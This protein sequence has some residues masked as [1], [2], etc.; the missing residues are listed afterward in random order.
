M[1]LQATRALRDLTRCVGEFGNGC[2]QRKYDLLAT[3]EKRTLSQATEVLRLHESLCFLRAFP[4]DAQLLTQVEHMLSVFAE[5]V[6]V[7]RHRDQ[8]ANTGIAGTPIYFRFFA[9]SAHWLARHWGAYLTIDWEE[10]ERRDQLELWLASMTLYCETQGL[11]AYAFDVREWIDRLKG[12][13]ETDAKFLLQRFERMPMS[14]RTSEVLLEDLDVPLALQPGPDTPARTREKYA[15]AAIVHQT[16]PLSRHRPT[17]KEIAKWRIRTRKVS[18]REG[19]KVIELARAIM[20]TRSRDLD[21]FAYGSPHGVSLVDCEGG[22]RIACIG[23]MP[24]RRLLL[25]TLYGYMVLKNGV[26]VGYGAIT[27]LFNSVEIAYTIFDTFRSADAAMMLG[28]VLTVAQKL[29]GA[30]TILIDSYQIGKDN[31][32]ALRSGAWWFYQKLGFRPRDPKALR[33]M[34]SE[35]KR[36]RINPTHRSSFKT[37]AQLAEHDLFLNLGDARKDVLGLLPLADI[38]LQLSNFLAQQFGVDR[39]NAARVCSRDAQRLLGVRNYSRFSFDERLAWNWWA[40]LVVILPNIKRWPS[41]DKR[42]LVRLIRAKGGRDELDYL[43]RF[44]DHRRLRSSLRRLAE[45]GR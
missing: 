8:L 7:R 42:A 29:F 41:A 5:R 12:P 18:P 22:I 13:G 25:E 28:W 26:P 31:E 38:G 19:R 36:M 32:D 33:V 24:E 15:S 3:L 4:D 2:G 34:R 27:G 45:R 37:L 21:A 30:D 14:R 11:D 44:N 35:Q 23:V 9:A 17:I 10:F 43:Q 40:P 20:A 16:R 6:D 1:S 39:E